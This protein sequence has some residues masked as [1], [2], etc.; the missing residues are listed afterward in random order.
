METKNLIDLEDI[1]KQV[2]ITNL[3]NIAFIMDGNR[4]WSKENNKDYKEGYIQG[5]IALKKCFGYC[6]DY[7]I[8]YISVFAFSTSNFNRPKKE[9]DDFMEVLV[10]Q[11]KIMM[12]DFMS[13]AVTAKFVGNIPALNDDLKN[14]FYAVEKKLKIIKIFYYK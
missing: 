11:L 1:K 4:S 8:K 10:N 9:I 14:F 2:K 12:K 3:K 5:S 6:H 13:L 7:G